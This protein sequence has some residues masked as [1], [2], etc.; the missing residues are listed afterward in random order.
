MATL[1][2]SVEG[3]DASW[4]LLYPAAVKP[5]GDA[6]QASAKCIAKR[7]DDGELLH[8]SFNK[9][10]NLLVDRL[11]SQRQH[12]AVRIAGE[13]FPVPP[14]VFQDSCNHFLRAGS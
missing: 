9:E 7:A 13:L 5:P 3:L 11:V 12:G 1:R 10:R 6:R 2:A 14:L 4:L 8:H